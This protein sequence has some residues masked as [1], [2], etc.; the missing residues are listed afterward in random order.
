M[1]KYKLILS[2]F[3]LLF[4]LQNTFAQNNTNSPYTRFGYGNINDNAAGERRAMGGVSIASRSNKTIN[5]V[6]PASYTAVDS[7]TF[8]FDLGVSAFGTYFTDHTS[9]K[10]TTF[11]GNLEYLTMQLPL[12]KYLG[13]SLG[14]L[15]YSFVGYDFNQ[16]DSV[17]T[18]DP[19]NPYL[20][21]TNSFDGTGGLTQ[22]YLGL[23]LKLFDHVA[24]GANAYYMWGEINNN[25]KQTFPSSVPNSFQVQNNISVSDIR[26]RY[27]AQFFH[28]FNKKHEWTLGL[29]YE[30]KSELNGEFMQT[31]IITSDTLK[32]EQGFDLPAYYGGG[33]YYTYE[34]RLS[35]GVDYSLQEWSKARYFNKT[36]SLHNVSKIA[37]GAEYIHD[38]N[39]NRYIDRM[40]FRLGC[41]MSNSYLNQGVNPLDNFGISFGLGLPL[42]NSKTMLNATF[43]YQKTG[44][45]QLL[46]E[47]L[48]KFTFSASINEMWFFKRKL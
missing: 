35:L 31:E 48:F 16:S 19:E 29:V 10:R 22:V 38:P 47:D 2:C 21:Y 3:V 5:T 12:T 39:G 24:L 4:F 28:T 42:R 14:L 41:N 11:N 13:M 17:F 15:P 45:K 26:F 6:N 37:L 1:Q 32:S 33:L 43:E 46:H 40:A 30:N 20:N 27:G 8:M 9:D 34:N 25:R 18:E 44:S 7:M 36:D 23:S